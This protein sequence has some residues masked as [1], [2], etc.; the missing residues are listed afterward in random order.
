M[1][2]VTVGSHKR[3]DFT[4]SNIGKAEISRSYFPKIS[5]NEMIPGAVHRSLGIYL[6]AEENLRQETIDEGFETS[7][8]L[9]WGSLPENEL[10]RIELSE[11]VPEL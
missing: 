8:H 7:H 5:D 4:G 3:S 11:F 6:T 2:I 1:C 10:M 9:K